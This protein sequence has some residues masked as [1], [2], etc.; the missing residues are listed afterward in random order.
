MIH[1]YARRY[2]PAQTTA[3]RFDAAAR[4][5]EGEVLAGVVSGRGDGQRVKNAVIQ[6]PLELLEVQETFQ[7]LAQRF[8]VQQ[9]ARLPSPQR[10]R[11]PPRREHSEPPQAGAKQS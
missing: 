1:A 7:Q 9:R 11:Q 10:R 3:P 4:L 5:V 2:R 8:V 6:V